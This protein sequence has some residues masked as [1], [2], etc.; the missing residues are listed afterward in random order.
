MEILQA[1]DNG[2]SRLTVGH[3]ERSQISF[4]AS[5]KGAIL[6]LFCYRCD[7]KRSFL[8]LTRLQCRVGGLHAKRS[9]GSGDNHCNRARKSLE[10][11]HS[12]PDFN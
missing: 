1:S 12:T 10:N 6:F 2:D 9:V 5:R 3:F 8:D 11:L 4:N 7:G